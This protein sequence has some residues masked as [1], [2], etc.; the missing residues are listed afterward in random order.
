VNDPLAQPAVR[1][2][3]R[4]LCHTSR[5]LRPPQGRSLGRV[6]TRC[7]GEVDTAR[8]PG[9]RAASGLVLT[10][11]TTGQPSESTSTRCTPNPSKPSSSVVS[12]LKFVAFV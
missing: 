2:R 7:F 1:Q 5:I 8:Y 9:Q 10:R 12:W 4:R 11:C 6:V 3:H